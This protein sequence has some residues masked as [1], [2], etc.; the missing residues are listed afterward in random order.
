MSKQI[1]IEL[2]D[3]KMQKEGWMFIGPILHCD[4][5]WKNQAAVYEKDGKYVVSG[6]DSTGETELNEPISKKEAETRIKESFKEIRK[7]MFAAI[8]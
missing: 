5:A 7:H 6:I 2:L 3:K 8:K 4:K 1:N